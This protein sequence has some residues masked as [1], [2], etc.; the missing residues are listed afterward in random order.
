MRGQT[1]HFFSQAAQSRPP[2]TH[3]ASPGSD[4]PIEC[5]RWVQLS[6]QPVT[7]VPGQTAIRS[8]LHRLGAAV[9]LPAAAAS[10]T[11]FLGGVATR[12]I[13]PDG[14]WADTTILHLHGGWYCAGSPD[15][16]QGR[17]AALAA[18]TGS[19]LVLPDYRL[20]PADPFPAAVHDALSAYLGL[21][22]FGT[23]PEQIVV[24]GD[25]AGGG[26][27][28]ALLL[29]LRD[30]GLGLPAA[31]VL[32]S[33]WADLAAPPDSPAGLGIH[34]GHGPPV[35]CCGRPGSPA[36]LAGLRG[37]VRA[38]AAAGS[39]GRPRHHAVRR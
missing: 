14:K 25:G 24:T 35:C 38:T 15:T 34:H 19:R 21:L 28:L 6:S 32:F 39:R 31:A 13:A 1:C 8:C 23:G 3:A 12:M 22:D 18:R 20:A 17:A 30:S 16:H 37:L 9:P 7:T 26:L 11:T 29:A 4:V 27:A 5:N 2:G 36:H 10:A 33:P